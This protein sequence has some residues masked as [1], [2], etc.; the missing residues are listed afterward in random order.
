MHASPL[1]ARSLPLASCGSGPATAAADAF[2][3]TIITMVS[4]VC[5]YTAEAALLVTI[6]LVQLFPESVDRA[7]LPVIGPRPGDL[8]QP[9]SSVLC[10]VSSSC[11]HHHDWHSPSLAWWL[12]GSGVV[13]STD[14]AAAASSAVDASIIVLWFFSLVNTG[15]RRSAP[16]PVLF[17]GLRP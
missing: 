2:H 7:I 3:E 8:Q 15:W 6:G 10:L 4:V 14:A 9:K 5:E 11:G 16:E 12:P 1:S 17:D 13:M